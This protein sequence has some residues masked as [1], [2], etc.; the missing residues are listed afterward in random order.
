MRVA[1]LAAGVDLGGTNVR[2]GLVTAKGELLVRES[3][4][5]RAEEGPEAVIGRMAELVKKTA[6]GR[7]KGV[8]DLAAVGLGSPGP[9]DSKRGVVHFTPNLPGWKDVPVA[10][11]LS[12]KLSRPVFLENDANSAAWGEFWMGA[13]KGCRDMVIF[14][15]GTGVGGGV[16]L[17]GELHRGVDE[18]AGH[19]GHII[20]DPEGPRCGCGSRGCLEVF[21]SATAVARRMREAIQRGARSPLG[22]FPP[23]RVDA[24]AV[25]EAARD[26]CPVARRIMEE[27]GRYLGIALATVVNIL[28]PQVAVY[29]GGL[30][31]AGEMLFSPL[32]EELRE[33]ALKPGAER[34]KIVPAELG[35]DAG[36]IGA[37]GCALKRLTTEARRHG[38]AFKS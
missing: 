31:R 19:L 22:S 36:V 15:L 2:A 26:G 23:E 13:G 8:E 24:R 25:F 4:P 33:R 1:S 6:A 7:G 29:S 14:T 34:V 30:S 38:G 18:M 37:A 32:E 3:V 10:R 35:D 17:R 9:L 21:A 12:E 27:T 11:I 20:I 16:I 5:T 28:D